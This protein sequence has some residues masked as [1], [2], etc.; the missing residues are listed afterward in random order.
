MQITASFKNTLSSI[1][2]FNKCICEILD[3]LSWDWLIG[4]RE[5]YFVNK[6]NKLYLVRYPIRE[7][8]WAK[9][10]KWIYLDVFTKHFIVC[11]WMLVRDAYIVLKKQEK[12]GGTYTINCISIIYITFSCFPPF[13][14]SFVRSS[15]VA[16]SVK[17]MPA[18]RETWVWSLGWEDPQEKEMASHSNILAWRIP[19]D[20]GAWRAAA[21]VKMTERLST[22]G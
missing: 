13:L 9:C 21:H 6:T 7:S 17:N 1:Y 12:E 2:R 4:R 22:R 15:L 11:S 10:A 5:L 14:S 18:M 8:F 20:V 16:Q 19:T 3:F